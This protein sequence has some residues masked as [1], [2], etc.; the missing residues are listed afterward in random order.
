M[1]V[2]LGPFLYTMPEL[3]SYYCFHTLLN[4]HLTSYVQK[5]LIGVHKG[6]GLLNRI[7]QQLDI[8]LYQYFKLKL[9]DLSVFSLRFILTLLANMQPLSEVILLWDRLLAMG[10]PYIIVFFCAHLM[11]IRKSLLMEQHAYK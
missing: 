10:I 6:I 11:K 1:N 3:D 4:D 2:L 8:K 7:L 5:N 9:N